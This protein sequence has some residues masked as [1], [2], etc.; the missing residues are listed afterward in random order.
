MYITLTTLWLPT[1]YIHKTWLRKTQ[2]IRDRTLS[3]GHV[4][5]ITPIYEAVTRL[6]TTAL[7]LQEGFNEMAL[8][9]QTLQAT[10]YNGTFIWKIPENQRHRHEAVT[11]RTVSLYSVPFYT[12]RH[13]YKLC[14]RLYMDGDGSGKGSHLSF[15]ITLMR[16]E[17]DAL[18]PWPFRQTVTMMLLDQDKQKDIVQSFRPEPSSS[19]FQRPR[20]EMNVASGCPLFAPI[21]ILNNRSYVKDDTMFLKCRVDTLGI[22]IE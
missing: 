18:L 19:S 7:Q 14:L 12:S 5:S 16:G 6:E 9:V 17:Y 2:T 8:M 10:S 15:F 4:T 13:G 1:E 20:N 3:M 11:G 22:N 21:S